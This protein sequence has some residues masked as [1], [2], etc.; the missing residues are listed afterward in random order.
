MRAG[1]HGPVPSCPQGILGS[2]FALKV[3]EQHR[4]KHFEK[5]RTP[6]ANL[7]QV[8]R[9]WR[10]P[11]RPFPG[12][13]CCP[14]APKHPAPPPAPRSCGS[15]AALWGARMDGG[16]REG[17]PIPIDPDSRE[18]R[19]P[20]GCLAPLL[21]GCQP[22]LPDG[23]VVL[24]RQPPARLQV[25]GRG[26]DQG[27]PGV[28]GGMNNL[29]NPEGP[30][31]TPG[32]SVGSSSTDTFPAR[33]SAEGPSFIL[34]ILTAPIPSPA[35]PSLPSSSTTG[36]GMM[37]QEPHGCAGGAAAGQELVLGV[38]PAGHR[39]IPWEAQVP[40]QQR[41]PPVIPGILPLWVDQRL[42]KGFPDL[43]PG[44]RGFATS[45]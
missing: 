40:F 43:S 7:I 15:T 6:A 16:V 25:G 2:G 10:V 19:S 14:L 34:I 4:Q 3:Q 20:A 38:D 29:G 22:G 1:S 27:V 39:G 21:H 17:P 13:L 11:P 24:L 44:C 36:K 41:V 30:C 12:M 35:T 5:R 8:R 42:P 33:E 26:E 45:L 18:S 31:G 28:P 9:G 23:H 37:P 32:G